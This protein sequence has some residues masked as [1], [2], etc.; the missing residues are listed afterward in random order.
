MSE[1]LRQPAV[2]V[3]D[4]PVFVHRRGSGRPLLMLH[5]NPDSHRLWLPMIDRLQAYHD[6]IAPDLPGFGASG[7]AGH[8]DVTLAGFARWVDALLDA[9]AIREP[10]DLVIH[11][12]GGFYGLAWAARHPERLR[13]LVITN[14][15]LH[16]DY[17]WH[18][19]AR[20][21]RS[22]LG[23]MAMRAFDWPLIGRSGHR[24][25]MQ[26]G[27]PGLSRTQI[28]DAYRHFHAGARAQVLR[29]YREADPAKFAPWLDALHA[30][31]AIRPTRV[32]WG[33]RDPFIPTHYAGRFGT[34][35]VQRLE[36]A[37]HWAVAEMPERCAALV[38]QHL[39]GA[40]RV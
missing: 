21:W 25:T 40:D 5:G 9:L 27:G 31:T 8:N 18:V 16:A 11:D 14:T 32:I 37:G 3:D 19:W 22:R 26:Q 12:I 35:D 24:L 39:A 20:L 2:R 4:A 10:I 15:L 36:A 17:R 38:R 34:T 13:R 30:V 7:V 28:D 6:C 1:G 29:I 23:E 33:M